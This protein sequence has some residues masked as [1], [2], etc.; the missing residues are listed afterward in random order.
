[1][2]TADDFRPDE[3]FDDAATAWLCERDEGFTPGRAQEF[4]AWRDQDPRHAAAVAR[5]ERALALIAEMPAVRV[6]LEARFGPVEDSERTARRGRMLLF[7]RAAWL[8]AAAAIALGAVAW[9]NVSERSAG[10]RYAAEPAAQRRVALRDGSVVDL[11]AASDVRVDFSARERRIKL[12][13][14]EAHF[15]V[16]ADTARPFVVTAG[17]V[18]VRAVGTAFNVRLVDGSVEVIVLE[19]KVEV[20]RA[21][22]R[23]QLAAG[24][25]TQVSRGAAAPVLKVEPAAPEAIRAALAW[26]DPMT[27]FNDVPLREVVAR[28]NQ[29]NATQL[30]LEDA[31]LGERKIGGVIALDQVEAFV[32]LLEQDGDVA[33]RRND[34]GVIALRRVR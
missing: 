31:P 23:S 15:Q 4:A 12:H 29:R 17:D 18:S 14:G 28:F 13:A 16:A 3:A 2:N 1:M 25:R 5:V 26:Q 32:R 7:P 8:S 22:A 11:N 33:A 19:G 27:T 20:V 6:P 21:G 10:E 30:V 24:D 34:A 9:W